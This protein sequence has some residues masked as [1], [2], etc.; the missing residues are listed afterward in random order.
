MN[1]RVPLLVVKGEIVGEMAKV[2]KKM[3]L[4][5]FEFVIV[6]AARQRAGERVFPRV[7]VKFAASGHTLV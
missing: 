3:V 1:F 7:N 6:D 5:V 2:A 4:Q